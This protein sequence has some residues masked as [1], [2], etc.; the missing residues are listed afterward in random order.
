[1]AT[2]RYIRTLML[3]PQAADRLDYFR[4]LTAVC[5][6]ITILCSW[7]LWNPDR[8]FP[9]APL[10]GTF[11]VLHGHIGS[12]YRLLLLGCGITLALSVRTMWLGLAVLM[13]IGFIDDLNRI[14]PDYYQYFLVVGFFY[15]GR[16]LTADKLLSSFRILTGGVYLWTGICKF[17]IHFINDISD[18][19]FETFH[20]H[21]ASPHAKYIILIVPVVEVLIG[22]AFLF[23][24]RNVLAVVI[25]FLLHAGIV[26]HLVVSHW[27]H[28]MI[29]FNVYL[30]LGNILLF[31]KA[32]PVFSLRD[33]FGG[34]AWP[35]RVAALLMVLLP[36]LSLVHWWPTYMSAS[37]YSCSSLR[38]DIYTC[39]ELETKF[40]LVAQSAGFETDSGN[41]ISLNQWFG[42]QT[43]CVPNPE[44]FVYNKMF[45]QLKQ[46]Y[47]LCDSAKLVVHR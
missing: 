26:T 20:L 10:V 24:K 37:M 19:F 2:I 25:A 9:T 44:A 18:S 41:Y 7:V 27:N 3:P 13:L 42:N 17:N 39:D 38:A 15:F 47:Q 5:F 33:V 28:T 36:S 30:A 21:P 46:R 14:R 35:Q 45:M 11:S 32:L 22:L 12:V 31:A 23:K 4:W 8:E 40:P 1:M 43:G 34:S 16:K 6:C 29:I